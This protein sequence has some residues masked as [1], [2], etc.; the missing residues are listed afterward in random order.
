MYWTFILLI[1]LSSTFAYQVNV[2][3]AGIGKRLLS[4]V[5]FGDS[6]SDTGNVYQLTNGTW[7]ISPPNFHGRYGNGPNWADG[8]AVLFKY[9]YAYGSATTDNSLIPGYADDGKVLVPGILQQVQQYLSNPILH[10]SIAYNVHTVW[11][12]AND[13]IDKPP[14][15]GQ[16]QVIIESLLSSVIALLEGG[17]KTIIV[18]NQ[19]PFQNVPALHGF[20]TAQELIEITAGVNLLINAGLQEI[21]AAANTDPG[22]QL[23]L[24][25]LHSLISNLYANPPSPVIYT[26]GS[27]WVV[28]G[29]IIAEGPCSDP[30]QYFFADTLHFS[31]PIQKKVAQAVG[32]FFKR[33][34]QPSPANYFYAV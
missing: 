22:V 30:N 9:N 28:Q 13:V 24:F 10:L 16:P 26:N 6:T 3:L 5:I 33:G 1:G 32:E 25:D 4:A 15:A 21:K 17:A 14:L 27:C 23:Y 8:L 18:F 7:P 20:A 12:G 31:A 19:E 34:F 29:A 11:G 2:N